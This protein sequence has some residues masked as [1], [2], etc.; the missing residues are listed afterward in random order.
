MGKCTGNECE[1]EAGK[2]RCP[3]CVKL[4]LK[5][6]YFC[7]QACFKKS[8]AAHK[9]IHSMMLAAASAVDKPRRSPAFSGYRFSGKLR[10]ALVTPMRTVPDHIA[11]PDYWQD[12]VPRSE[13]AARGKTTIKVHTPEEIERIR[14][15]CRL[16]RE[17]LDLAGAAVKVGVTCEE[18]DV[19][20]H[21]A[22]IE[23][24]SYPS[25]LNYHNFPKS[26][27][28][29]VNEVI[30]HGIPDTRPLEDGDIVNIDITLYHQGMHGDLNATFLVGDVDDESKRLVRV[31]R[32]CL[33]LAIAE[34]KPGA[35]Y[36]DLGK[37]ISKFVNRNGFQVVRSYCGHGIG[38]L[39]HTTPNVPH[40]SNNK[41]VG[42]MQPGH[43][44]TIEPMINMGTW[45]DTLWPDQWTAVT[46]DGRRS[47]QFEETLLVTETGVEILTGKRN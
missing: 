25:P 32:E 46:T 15:V 13:E 28:T 24:N 5:D 12:G 1:E 31:A 18:I 42:V 47:A 6:S 36:R 10:P 17:V 4:G 27:C 30:C 9:G 23:R 14:T 33:D 35:L 44:F 11:R 37:V 3:T 8:W 19:L 29:S 22:C 21:Q 40:Y 7:S 20:V 45:K 38:E 16:G 43:V 2:L 34:V 39:F 26:C 41:A